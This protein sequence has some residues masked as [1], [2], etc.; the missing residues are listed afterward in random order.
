MQYT[1]KEICRQCRCRQYQHFAVT[2][3]TGSGAGGLKPTSWSMSELAGTVIWWWEFE[4]E[5]YHFRALNYYR[6][7]GR[8]E[9]IRESSWGIKLTAK[10]L[11]EIQILQMLLVWIVHSAWQPNFSDFPQDTATTETFQTCKT[12]TCL[13]LFLPGFLSLN[14]TI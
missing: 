9:K 2:T 14:K 12:T 10:S 6:S 7:H 8:V 5:L 13:R 1:C 4:Q 3:M 11:I